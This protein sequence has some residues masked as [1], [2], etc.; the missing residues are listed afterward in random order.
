MLAFS[1]SLLCFTVS[2]QFGSDWIIYLTKP[3]GSYKETSLRELLPHAFGP[4]H[5]AKS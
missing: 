1:S 4:E 2:P 5:L 3:D